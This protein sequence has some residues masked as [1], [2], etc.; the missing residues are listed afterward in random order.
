MWVILLLRSPSQNKHAWHVCQFWKIDNS[1]ELQPWF[2]C[3]ASVWKTQQIWLRNSCILKAMCTLHV[4]GRGV[5]H[6]TSQS[7]YG[8]SFVY[9]Y[10]DMEESVIGHR[11]LPSI[12]VVINHFKGS[13]T[14]RPFSHHPSVS[15]AIMLNINAPNGVTT[16]TTLSLLSSAFRSTVYKSLVTLWLWPGGTEIRFAPKPCFHLSM[17]QTH[18]RFR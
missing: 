9:A 16:G 6:S 7:L 4:S 10:N 18:T 13:L 12:L 3:Y 1:I 17:P 15:E 11:T 14:G 2:A 5:G 8:P